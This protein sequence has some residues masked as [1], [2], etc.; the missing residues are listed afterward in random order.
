MADVFLLNKIISA[1]SPDR[2][3]E[4]VNAFLAGVVTL[5]PAFDSPIERN[6]I[7][8]GNG[9]KTYFATIHYGAAGSTA[10]RM[11]VIERDSSGAL[12]KAMNDFLATPFLEP[13]P[14]FSDWIVTNNIILD[15]G[16]KIFIA[17]FFYR[18]G[19]A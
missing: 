5:N 11:K 6:D 9:N 2:F 8:L 19:I 15:N 14:E 3:E 16:N 17:T 13:A 12:E 4:A 7:L 10:T 18:I 1:D